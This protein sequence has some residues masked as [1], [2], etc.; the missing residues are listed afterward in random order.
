MS[1]R[2]T[3]EGANCSSEK[4]EDCANCPNPKGG[5]LDLI[6]DTLSDH[7]CFNQSGIA[8]EAF[9]VSYFE[10]NTKQQEEVNNTFFNIMSYHDERSVLTTLQLDAMCDTSNQQRHEVVN[11]DVIFVDPQALVSPPGGTSR[12]GLSGGPIPD[13]KSAIDMA[14]AGDVL[15]LRPGDYT[16]DRVIRKAITLRAVRRDMLVAGNATIRVK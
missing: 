2:H 16:E 9:G 13:L 14:G 6:V 12:T 1:V 7:H 15:L 10:L 8:K 3:H 5:T 4:K 11:G